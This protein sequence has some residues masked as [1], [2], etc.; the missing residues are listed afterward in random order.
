MKTF[1]FS[2]LTMLVIMVSAAAVADTYFVPADYS[3]IQAAI[4]AIG[5]GD[6][7]VVSD[8]T[9]TGIGNK[10]LSLQ[11]KWITVRSENGPENCIIDCEFSGRGFIIDGEETELSIIDGFTITHGSTVNSFSEYG[12]GIYIRWNEE[13]ESPRPTIRNCNLISCLA[14][15]SGGGMAIRLTDATLVNCIFQGC[16]AVDGGGLFIHGLNGSELYNVTFQDNYCGNVG[17]G[18]KIQS[19]NSTFFNCR[20]ERN[21]GVLG[22][23][24]HCSQ[25]SAKFINCF[26]RRNTALNRYGNGAGVF[27]NSC[28]PEFHFCTIAQNIILYSSDACAGIAGTATI[29]N[30]IIYCNTPPNL[31]TGSDMTYSDVEGGYSGTGNFDASP[32][33]DFGD[34]YLMQLIAGSGLDSP[35][36][37][38]GCYEGESYADNICFYDGEDYIYL[39]ET[40]TR[41]DKGPDIGF[42][43][44]G[45]H[46][47]EPLGKALVRVPEDQPTIQDGIDAALHE[48]TVLVANGI[49]S[50]PG[51]RDLDLNDKKLTITS[52]GGPDQCIIQVD[53][54]PTEYHRAFLLFDS[55]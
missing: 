7:V 45:F 26:I 29:S 40:T 38:A 55:G 36:S 28:N 14:E 50:G 17:G 9:Y 37:D 53:G 8:G 48:G 18:L 43:D 21:N 52:T 12:G 46:H 49:Y 33:F 6:E 4:D 3:T 22:G 19:S 15:E 16:T 24:I 13:G 39:S 31:S 5:H 41:I 30:S 47:I 11:S 1:K 32:C 35:C 20:F 2:L 23:A 44:I 42:V 34:L 51:N 25:A 27:V 10:N 54:S